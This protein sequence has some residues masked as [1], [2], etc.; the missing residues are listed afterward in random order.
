VVSCDKPNLGMSATM[1]K[2]E[3]ASNPRTGVAFIQ[4][5]QK[6]PTQKPP[7]LVRRPKNFAPDFEKHRLLTA[8]L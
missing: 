5:L 1:R 2:T 3:H 4:N 6:G 8:R 7:K